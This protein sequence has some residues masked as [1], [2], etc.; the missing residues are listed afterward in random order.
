MNWRWK[1]IERANRRRKKRDRMR[2]L[3]E[4]FVAIFD[5]WEYW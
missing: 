5:L 2:V 1:E 3:I 4:S